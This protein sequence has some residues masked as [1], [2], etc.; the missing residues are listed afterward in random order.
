MHKISEIAQ[1][2]SDEV[3]FVKDLSIGETIKIMN[4]IKTN[5]LRFK[6]DLEI[7]ESR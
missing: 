2:E 5:D 1:M 7:E 3:D 6:L 4:D